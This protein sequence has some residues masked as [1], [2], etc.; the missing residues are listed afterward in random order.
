MH[1]RGRCKLELLLQE[2]P[3]WGME[4][5]HER[6]SDPRISARD[7]ERE[8]SMDA[9]VLGTLLQHA[10]QV[11]QQVQHSKPNTTCWYVHILTLMPTLP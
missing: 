10:N 6:I 5:D 9:Q 7:S 2:V 8:S 11:K 3:Q 4:I 1:K